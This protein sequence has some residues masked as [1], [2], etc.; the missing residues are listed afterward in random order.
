MPI[1]LPPFDIPKIYIVQVLKNK[2][3]KPSYAGWFPGMGPVFCGVAFGGKAVAETPTT[4]T[5][6]SGTTWTV[7]DDW[8]W[9]DPGP[10]GYANYIDCY[11]GG[12]AGGRAVGGSYGSGG[13]GGGAFA[14]LNNFALTPGA[15]VY[16]QI[17]SGGLG[18][19]AGGSR[20]GTDTWINKNSAASPSSTSDGARA[21]AG[22]TGRDGNDSTPG[23]GGN[24]GYVFNSI[25]DVKYA[26]GS[27]SDGGWGPEDNAWGGGGGGCAG[28]SGAG[29]NATNNNGA[30]GGGGYAGAGGLG[31]TNLTGG[32][33]NAYGGGGGGT[34]S[35]K[36]NYN[37][38]SGYSGIIV[39]TYYAY[40]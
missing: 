29:S 31:R 4:I 21:D 1:D 27:G 7:P 3:R 2:I 30:A 22:V 15:T 8:N 18:S 38:G 34:W 14:R 35:S 19:S 28:T 10:G 33:G 11:G 6:T 40:L 20:N 32:A 12:G 17:G 5:L 37:G 36:S 39:I 26:G 16:I 23:V 9:E 24:G 13:G 25:G